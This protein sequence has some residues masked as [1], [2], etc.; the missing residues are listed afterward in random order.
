LYI[1]APH[2]LEEWCR[3]AQ[4]CASDGDAGPWAVGRR[5]GRDG[6]QAIGK[7]RQD[8]SDNP[9]VSAERI[10]SEAAHRRPRT[11]AAGSMIVT[12]SPE[13]FATASA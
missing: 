8:Q 3:L 4:A 1:R 13:L 12:A 11:W 9:S 7:R 2:E 6:R 5:Q 10:D